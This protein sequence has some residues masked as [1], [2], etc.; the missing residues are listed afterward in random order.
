[1]FAFQEWHSALEL[2]R[3]VLR[4][5]HAFYGMHDFSVVKFSKYNQYESF[6]QP[7]IAYLKKHGVNFI[8]GVSVNNVKFDIGDDA[9]VAKV[10]E[11]TIH[12]KKKIINVTKDDLVFITNGSCTQNSS[13]GSHS[14]PAKLNTQSGSI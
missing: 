3:Y 5:I 4:F 14:S 2:R 13:F 10:I 7:I 6:I 9:K 11:A 12:R 1:M 8:F